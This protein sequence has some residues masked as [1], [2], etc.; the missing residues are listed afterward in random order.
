MLEVM[1]LLFVL[2][3]LLLLNISDGAMLTEVGRLVFGLVNGGVNF[4]GDG[5]ELP[6]AAPG[7]VVPANCR[8]L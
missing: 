3:L 2:L 6:F 1:L 7:L 4:L 8:N 5:E